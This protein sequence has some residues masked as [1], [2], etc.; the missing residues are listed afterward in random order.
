ML[1][2]PVPAAALGRGRSSRGFWDGRRG[3]FGGG[4]AAVVSGG[5]AFDPVPVAGASRQRSWH[6]KRPVADHI[7]KAANRGAL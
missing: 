1:L 7:D 2:P 4:S 6:A 5:C 3:G